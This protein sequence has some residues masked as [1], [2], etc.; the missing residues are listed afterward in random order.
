MGIKEL[1]QNRRFSVLRK[2]NKPI[3]AS[4]DSLFRKVGFV[5][6]LSS[7]EQLKMVDRLCRLFSDQGDL[8]SVCIYLKNNK[9]IIPN[10]WGSSYWLVLH[11]KQVNWYGMIRSGVADRFVHQ[12]YDVLINLSPEYCFTT[13]YIMALTR[14]RLK[15]GRYAHPKSPYQLILGIDQELAG[16][17]FVQLLYNSMKRMKLS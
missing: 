1:F 16:E 3:Y 4:P 7:L 5:L 14:S 2:R 6:C 12:S 11:A 17:E 15:V 13:S 10:S 9:L 8:C